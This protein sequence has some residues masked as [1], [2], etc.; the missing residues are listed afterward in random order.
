MPPR[1]TPMPFGFVP[2]G[3]GLAAL[4]VVC[5]AGVA[6]GSVDTL[7]RA[8]TG[9]VA[10]VS[11]VLAEAVCWMR[12]WVARA[13]DAW[14]AGGVGAV[15]LACVAAARNGME[16][17]EVIL[18]GLAAM[19]FVALPCAAVRWYVRDRAR[20][21]GLTPPASHVAVPLPRP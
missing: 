15:L 16:F 11:F 13:A 3:M 18:F 20:Q 9:S 19:C 7:G 2:L 4:G 12:P 14:A 10:L 21:L 5:T 17:D 6:M 8:L 1:L